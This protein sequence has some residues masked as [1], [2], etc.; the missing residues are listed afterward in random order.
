MVRSLFILVCH[1]AFF[2]FILDKEVSAQEITLSAQIQIA[3]VNRDDL[4]ESH[5]ILI[6]NSEYFASEDIISL[7]SADADIE[8]IEKLLVERIGYSQD[9]IHKI[10]GAEFTTR[11]S[12]RAEIFRL[13]ETIPRDASVLIYYV[14]HGFTF[15]GVQGNF[16]VPTSF[17]SRINAQTTR[18]A[19][20]LA[21]EQLVKLETIVSVLSN[22]GSRDI[23][24]FYNACRN[25]AFDRS[26]PFSEDSILQGLGDDYGEIV[27]SKDFLGIHAFYAAERGGRAIARVDVRNVNESPLTL[28]GR[29]LV[30]ILSKTPS[31]SF[32]ALKREL[33][34]NTADLLAATAIRPDQKPRPNYYFNAT[35]LQR[36][37]DD[38][39]CLAQALLEDG[40]SACTNQSGVPFGSERTA[41]PSFCTSS[42]QQ[43]VELTKSEE[44]VLNYAAHF[45]SCPGAQGLANSWL[46]E[47]RSRWTATNSN[48]NRC[49]AI[50]GFLASY[51]DTNYTPQANE[52]LESDACKKPEPEAIFDAV[53][54]Q[55]IAV[56]KNSPSDEI[57]Q[58]LSRLEA[59][60][61]ARAA[62]NP[63]AALLQHS[64]R[65]QGCSVSR[66]G[67]LS[68]STADGHFGPGSA[69]GIERYNSAPSR[70]D[71]C[72]VAKPLD[73]IGSRAQARDIE[74]FATIWMP[75][76]LHNLE[77][78]SACV[79]ASSAPVCG[80]NS[81]KT[82]EAI[83]GICVKKTCPS[84][85][86]LSA[87]TGDC[88]TPLS[89]TKSNEV[90]SGGRCV[91]RAGYKRNTSGAC[92]EPANPSPS[93][94]KNCFKVNGSVICD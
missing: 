32:D 90:A 73:R 14:G 17:N 26:S 68:P 93:P 28:F 49:E 8:A 61:D 38:G 39:F 82:F 36:L 67:S 25:D 41:P 12:L 66:S 23:V 4:K 6:G 59:S 86:R 40:S 60:T 43:W 1:C 77:T 19:V 75:D 88:Y 45:S 44:L 71:E 18:G 27:P 69:S 65:L 89:C 33:N 37:P 54:D 81:D 3:P 58:A 13:D 83:D 56:L 46:A 50:Q 91:C 51:P 79:R 11:S 64:L 24:L 70:L 30:D 92:Y 35:Q 52:I 15:E 20:R 34:N 21:I 10:S 84:G 9:Q 55:T 57:R 42:F 7:P 48:T 22:Q 87:R 76:A 78:I 94:T 31:I 53:K 85:Q 62:Y 72:S 74:Y 63:M 80:C 29:T 47:M 5:A 16:I 2:L